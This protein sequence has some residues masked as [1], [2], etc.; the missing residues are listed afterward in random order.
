MVC[1]PSPLTTFPLMGKW[2][3]L[4]G[5]WVA[6]AVWITHACGVARAMAEWIVNGH[7]A[8][9]VHECD[10]NR[11][12][13]HQLG[14][15]HIEE[16]GARITV[17]VYDLLHPLQ[18]MESPRPLR[19]TGFYQRQQET[20]WLLPSKLPATS[21]RNGTKPTPACSPATLF[22]RVTSGVQNSGRRLSVPRPRRIG[23]SVGLFDITTLRRIEVTGDGALEF[24]ER[25]TTGNLRKKPGSITYCLILNEK[26]GIL[27]DITVMR[28]GEQEFFVGVNS[29]IDINYLRQGVRHR[30]PCMKK[31]SLQVL[32]GWDSSDLNR[33]N[34]PNL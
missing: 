17:E 30:A 33:G 14:S 6:E 11:F 1:S 34:S 16:R 15:Q 23:E 26:A 3:G 25:L 10:V 9:A 8:L 5:F 32:L 19:T 21:G 24:L 4:K 29:N 2:S 13:T 20:R 18:P 27:S 31:T 28:R 12:D 22:R 7:P